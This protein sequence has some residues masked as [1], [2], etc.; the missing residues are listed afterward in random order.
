[1]GHVFISYCHADTA[2]VR[3]L[4]LHLTGSGLHV[5]YDDELQH[6]DAWRK[7][8]EQQIDA[9]DAFVVVMT[10]A[11]GQSEWVGRE[12]DRAVAAGRPIRPILLE[13]A[14]FPR[15]TDVHYETV[16]NASMPGRRFLADLRRL[17][18]YDDA[19]ADQVR[20]P[21]G[22]AQV[23][24][25]DLE[26]AGGA[27]S[28]VFSPD[29]FHVAAGT[30]DGPVHIWNALTGATVQ[31]LAGHGG[32]V[33][34]V[35]YRGDGRV[36]ATGGWDATV[37][38]WDSFTGKP[39]RT[40][41]GH[42]QDVNAL[43]FT[44]DGT[45]IVSAG[46]DTLLRVWDVAT[47]QREDLVV[48]H[49]EA[50]LGLATDP[51]GRYLATASADR[52]VVL[53]DARQLRPVAMFTGHTDGVAAVAFSPDGGCLAAAGRDRTIRL[54]RL[55]DGSSTGQVLVGHTDKVWTVAFSHDSRHIASG[56]DDRTVRVWDVATG[57]LVNTFAD[58]GGQIWGVVFSPA[59]WWLAVACGSRERAA[60]ILDLGP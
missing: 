59:T 51:A 40:L 57:R 20:P 33:S 27:S 37:R 47:G 15:F 5:W 16:H 9:C 22:R 25:R 26:T 11:A 24:T 53:W 50:I 7:V 35:A 42:T 31:R 52:S 39:I 43:A 56:A 1:M 49:S 60:R 4:D 13:G 55:T 41:E 21:A 28:V 45:R 38:L 2:Y 29:G 19:L 10:P 54:W 32:L 17:A 44:A 3:G 36:L 58:Y 8:V 18:G 14:A 34:T 23:P 46:E 48:P 30:V 6:G 12:I